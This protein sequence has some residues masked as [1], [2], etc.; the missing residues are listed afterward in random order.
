MAGRLTG[1]K[2]AGLQRFAPNTLD[3]GGTI[4]RHGHAAPYATVVLGGSYEEAGDAGRTVAI[5]GDVLLHAPFACHRDLVSGT[6]TQVLDLPLPFDARRRPARARLADPDFAVRLA[7]RDPHEAALWVL[8]QLAPLA[9]EC[10]DLPDRLAAALRAAEPAQ[11][12]HWAA[13]N[14]F[15]REHVSRQFRLAYGVTAARY[16]TENIAR[17]A[18]FA[19]VGGD[20]TLAQVAAATGF[21]DQAHMSRAV[22]WLTGHPPGVWRR[23]RRPGGRSPDEIYGA[24]HI[25]S[26][27]DPGDVLNRAA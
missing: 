5:A 21:A 26:R 4:E 12:G 22:A 10:D 7:E 25:G 27:T 23:W 14:G 16:R 18:W 9:M 6:R 8:D 1:P 19:A 13:Q 11:I 17:E 2:E 20:E 15:S 3:L 24:G